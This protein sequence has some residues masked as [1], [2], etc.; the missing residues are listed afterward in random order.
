MDHNLYYIGETIVIRGHF[1]GHNCSDLIDPLIAHEDSRYSQA[2]MKR[3]APAFVHCNL[4][5]T[6]AATIVFILY[7]ARRHEVVVVIVRNAIPV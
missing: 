5:G 1:Y 4:Y 6:S 7:S 3:K 2:P